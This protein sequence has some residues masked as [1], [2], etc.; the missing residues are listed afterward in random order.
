MNTLRNPDSSRSRVAAV[1]MWDGVHRGHRFLIDLVRQRAEAAGAAP[2]VVTFKHHPMLT[3]SPDRAPRL[4]TSNSERLSL[5]DSA[6][7]ADC[8]LLDFNEQMR[9]LTA[10][11]FL[12]MLSRD[13]AVTELVVGFNNR[14]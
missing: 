7:V 13:Y 10:E 8:I 6:G 9:Q 5:L 11:Q 14:F 3:V 12:T 1:G 4:L 2:A